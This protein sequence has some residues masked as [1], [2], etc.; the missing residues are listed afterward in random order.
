MPISPRR[1][2][3]PHRVVVGGGEK[4]IL[5]GDRNALGAVLSGSGGSLFLA[6][7]LGIAS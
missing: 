1:S 5:P 7:A 2:P 4:A 3:N 6:P